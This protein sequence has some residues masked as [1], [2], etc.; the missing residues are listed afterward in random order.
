MEGVSPVDASALGSDEEHFLAA[1]LTEYYG[2]L[3]FEQATQTVISQLKYSTRHPTTPWTRG[4]LSKRSTATASDSVIQRLAA[5]FTDLRQTI[6][7]LNVLHKV[8]IRLVSN[9]PLAT[10][11]QLL[12]HSA[13]T[14]LQGLGDA[15][16]PLRA[17]LDLM[18]ITSHQAVR[19]L[20]TLLAFPT[21]EQFTDFLRVLDLSGCG[22]G[23]RL[24][25]QL[26]ALHE[27]SASVASGRFDALLRLKHL[28]QQQAH[29]ETE[30]SPGLTQR[31]VLAALDVLDYHQLFPE[32]SRLQPLAAVIPTEEA[33]QLAAALLTVP[34]GRLLAH[35]DAGVGKTTTVQQLAAHLP[36]GSVVLTYDC[37][38]AG[39]YFSLN[40]GRHTLPRALLQLSNELAVRTGLPLLTAAPPD[41]LD[42]IVHFTGR[43]AAAAGVVD[44]AGG[45][46]VL[47]IDAADNSVAKAMME[48]ERRSF[49]P[50]LWEIG[51]PANCRLL[52]TTRTGRADSLQAP[53]STPRVELRGFGLAASA[54][55]LAQAFPS[56]STRSQLAFHKRTAGNPRVQRY[57]LDAAQQAGGSRAAFLHIF[58]YAHLTPTAI[59]E[60]LLRVAVHEAADPEQAQRHLTTLVCL[61]RPIPLAIFAGACS[62]N[63]KAAAN[64]CRAL[65]PGVVFADNFVTFHDEDFENHLRDR[66]QTQAL[67]QEVHTHL[68][69]YFRKL[70]PTNA[71][72]A[73]AVATHYAAAERHTAVLDLVLHGPGLQVITDSLRRTQTQR[74]RLSLAL[75]AAAALRDEAAGARILLLAAEAMRTNESVR[76]LV[77]A[78]LDL[79]DRLGD[80][81]LLHEVYGHLS[82]RHWLGAVHYRL[83]AL[84]ARQPATRAQAVEHWYQAAAWV[85]RYEN[86]PP[87]EHSSWE[88]TAMDLANGAQA[89]FWLTGPAAARRWLAQWQPDELVLQ[90]AAILLGNLVTRLSDDEVEQHMTTSH[91]SLPLQCLVLAA[92]WQRGRM[93]NAGRVRAVAARLPAA[94]RQ[95]QLPAPLSQWPD[96]GLPTSLSAQ[97]PLLLAELLTRQQ[98][99]NKTILLVLTELLPAFPNRSPLG[100]LPFPEFIAPLRAEALKAVLQG[101]DLTTEQL[102]PSRYRRPAQDEQGRRRSDVYESERRTFEET[103]GAMLPLYLL[104]ARA[105]VGTMP[106]VT[107]TAAIDHGL[108]QMYRAPERSPASFAARQRMWLQA[109][110]VLAAQLPGA[111]S[112]LDR[113][114]GECPRRVGRRQG[115]ELWQDLAAELLP[116]PAYRPLALRWLEQA[117]DD[118]QQDALPV[119]ERWQLLLA[120]AELAEPYDDL[121]CQD[122]YGRALTAAHQGV[123]DDVASRLAVGAHLAASLAPHLPVTEGHP[124]GTELAALVEAYRFYVTEN[125]DMPLDETVTAVTVLSPLTGAALCGRWETCHLHPLTESVQMLVRA[126]TMAGYWP[127]TANSW[128]LR[129]TGEATDISF[130]A[131]RQLTALAAGGISQRPMLEALLTAF[132]EW[133]ETRV[134]PS[135]RHGALHRLSKWAVSH[136][137]ERLPAVQRLTRTL[138]FVA[139]LRCAPSPPDPVDPAA[140]AEPGQ[141]QNTWL[142]KAHQGDVEAFR[143]GNPQHSL[144]GEELLACL[145][146]LGDHVPAGQRVAIL[147]LVSTW[148]FYAAR[149]PDTGVQAL[150]ELLTRW[151][152]FSPVREW[153]A[154]GLTTYFGRHLHRLVGESAWNCHLEE[155]CALPLADSSRAALL[156]DGVAR[157]LD[158]LDPDALCRLAGALARP[159]APGPRHELTRWLLARLRQQLKD[160]GKALPFE[161]LVPAATVAAG[162]PLE[163]LAQLTWAQ[164]GHPDKRVRWRVVHALRSLIAMPAN[165]GLRGPLLTRL[166]ELS[167]TTSSLLAGEGTTFFWLGARVWVLILIERLAAELPGELRPHVAAISCHLYNPELP[168]AQIRGLARRALLRLL[169]QDSRLLSAD[170]VAALHQANQPVACLLERGYNLDGEALG[171]P[172]RGEERFHFDQ[173]DTLPYWCEPLGDVF[174]QSRS[175]VAQLAEQW[176]C[177]RWGYSEAA[178]KQH[179]AQDLSPVDYSLLDHRHGSEPTIETLRLHLTHHA[180]QCVAGEWIATLPLPLEE[181]QEADERWQEWLDEHLI[182]A[183][184]EGWLADLLG[185][186]PLQPEC[187]GQL[188]TP[189]LAKKSSDFLAAL[190]RHEPGRD[191]WQLLYSDCTFGEDSR[192]GR[193]RVGSVL[194]DPA[195]APALLRALQLTKPKNYV[196]PT[197]GFQR[198]DDYWAEQVP[199]SFRLQFLVQAG[200]QRGKGLETRDAAARALST[201]DL[202]PAA[203]LLRATGLTSRCHGREYV[204]RAGRLILE[205]EIWDDDQRDEPENRYAPYSAGQ[206]LWIRRDALQAYLRRAGQNL[207]VSVKLQ[208]NFDSSS[209]RDTPYDTG[210]HVLYLFR[211]DGTVETL[212]G[213]C[214]PW[215]AHHPGTSA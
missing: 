181:E 97:W 175:S 192:S 63:E 118:A 34:G 159:L 104:R 199:A 95:R 28:V 74:Q 185:P 11:L 139:G 39:E 101:Q 44:A 47:A 163:T 84:Y 182:H 113:L 162:T 5:S 41:P 120:S 117:A 174:G 186:P 72:A 83:A 200:S 197:V 105:L 140:Y 106:L 147:E 161:Q 13:Q 91:L 18:P 146:V 87:D 157:Q 60:D 24:Q 111:E 89:V 67:V 176:I 209:H 75:H 102:L 32:P 143:H 107:A 6:S 131:C 58:R 190:G 35:G 119:H 130:E 59:F 42:F 96:A 12:W 142:A 26:A 150:G 50:H 108:R 127:I 77:R 152:R 20:A 82:G 78:N 201:S 16:V 167:H 155:L 52:M 7:R 128:L 148:R 214:P 98:V 51:L 145:R 38:G 210:K 173:I 99:E 178:V 126:T 202:L 205:H 22:E 19:Q 1:D 29:P 183:R 109:A 184:T 69:D 33:S 125:T 30:Q 112:L 31:D 164:L 23:T 179:D 188:P 76:D 4:R 14:A 71:Y 141:P 116:M 154:A 8:R 93:G 144:S 55:H 138:S 195:T 206:R 85:R 172:A 170:E 134:R 61:Q 56:A 166:L 136:G 124:L 123:G 212:A 135:E 110:G 180:L 211:Q 66:P 43:L 191:D 196:F 10:D 171:L 160:D 132:C 73:R 2:G 151:Q 149:P 3:H 79:A 103:I 40:T 9:Q 122:F 81:T 133:A 90:S 115:R 156:L 27:L 25:Q 15:P 64:F 68:G 86:R 158:H 45:L 198:G 36:P 187:W 194:V 193:V 213:S 94:I 21:E 208:R 121:L 92:L 177:N 53:V 114:F 215:A 207:L 57:W 189:W 17:L 88:I 153:A 70:A 204:D 137:F 169:T 48:G 80:A 49:V 62:L 54:A 46:L 37:Y 203:S 65:A 129:L 100:Q 168:H 165:A